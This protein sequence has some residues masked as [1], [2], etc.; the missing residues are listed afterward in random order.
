MFLRIL[1]A[2]TFVFMLGCAP[3]QVQYVSGNSTPSTTTDLNTADYRRMVL[4]LL[5][6]VQNSAKSYLL[7]QEQ[8]VLITRIEN[9]TTSLIDGAALEETIRSVF[10]SNSRFTFIDTK[11][12]DDILAQLE[13]GRTG[14]TD[15]GTAIK[16]GKLLNAQL[17]LSGS[18]T[19]TIQRAGRTKDASY[20]FT[21][22]LTNIENGAII[23]TGQ[24]E[25]RKMFQRPR[26]GF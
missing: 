5:Q 9:R 8:V 1:T 25:I 19:S 2:L 15:S 13:M 11:T 22:E 17:L 14:L 23:W 10:S 7:D 12:L 6:Q 3:K 20:Q 18:L 4:E 21:I 24:S 26:A 16:A